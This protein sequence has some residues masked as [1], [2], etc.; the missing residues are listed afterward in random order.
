MNIQRAILGYQCGFET[1]ITRMT[2]SL[3]RA[4]IGIIYAV[5]ITFVTTVPIVE[6]GGISGVVI[7]VSAVIGLVL[8]FGVPIKDFSIGKGQASFNFAAPDDDSDDESS[9]ND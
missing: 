8:I 7:A 4:L 9:Q 2:R 6:D 3:R 1:D 5:L